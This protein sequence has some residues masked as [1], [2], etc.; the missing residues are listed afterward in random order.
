M[1]PRADVVGV[2]SGAGRRS[3]VRLPAAPTSARL[4]RE[5][6]RRTTEGADDGRGEL[7]VTEL[8]AN[9]IESAS[10]EPELVVAWDG[11]V[12]HVEVHDDGPG[13]P[14]IRDAEGG[15]TSGRG[16]S[17]VGAV[18]DR[19]GARP[20]DTGKAV[21]AEIDLRPGRSATAEPQ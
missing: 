9:A 16:L 20:T 17:I 6:L 19:W 5:V 12:L 10:S 3:C 8:V 18:A 4:A 2:P 15:A 11:A 13:W 1:H 21:W 7:V 14:R